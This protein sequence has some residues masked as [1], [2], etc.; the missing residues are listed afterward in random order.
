MKLPAR[1][2]PCAFTLVEIMVAVT[3]FMMVMISIMACWKVIISGTQTGETAAAMAQRARTSMRAVEDSLNNLE[4]S[5]T[6]IRYY[7]F[8]ADTSNPQFAA[9]S[10]SAR[11]PQSFLG[12]SYFG[13]NVMRRVIFDVE[14]GANDKLNLVMT[15]YPLLAIPNDRFPPKSI[16]LARDVSAFVLEFW[17]PKE[18]DWL[19]DFLKT[20]EVPPMIRITLGTGHSP[21]DA[22]LPFEVIQRIVVPP[23]LAHL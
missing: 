2:S 3:L 6:N 21:R 14:K 18:D 23:V 10:F 7:S 17:S 16:V 5:V 8:V 4:I 9:L 22:N 15:Q 12:S 19:S 11:L 13:D 20:N 1:P